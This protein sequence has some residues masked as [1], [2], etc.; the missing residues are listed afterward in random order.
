MS[1]RLLAVALFALA[2]EFES[3]QDRSRTTRAGSSQRHHAASVH[4]ARDRPPPCRPHRWRM[5]FVR[6]EASAGTESARMKRDRAEQRKA[7]VKAKVSERKAHRQFRRAKRASGPRTDLSSASQSTGVDYR[8][9][10]A[11]KQKAIGPG[12]PH[13][14]RCREDT[15]QPRGP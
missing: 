11:A 3:P 4:R 12:N 8:R 14:R 15:P 7:Q 13:R 5:D 10:L 2:A 1:R 9:N 6:P